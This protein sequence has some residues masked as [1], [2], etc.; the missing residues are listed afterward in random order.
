MRD[1]SRRLIVYVYICPGCVQAFC[2]AAG[3]I[4]RLQQYHLTCDGANR[5]NAR[6]LHPICSYTIISQ[7]LRPLEHYPR[8]LSTLKGHAQLKQLH[9]YPTELI[10]ENILISRIPLHMR[11]ESFIRHENHIRRQHHKSLGRVV[12]EL[13][14]TFPV[15]FVP[16]L[17]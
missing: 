14:G 5:Y 10:K 16:A 12:L 3:Q 7:S 17:V 15:S 2:T 8:I 1:M 6:T 9:N 4:I 13:S 11:L